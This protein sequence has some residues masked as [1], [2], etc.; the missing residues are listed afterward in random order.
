MTQD[1]NL[2]RNET[3]VGVYLFIGVQ[4]TLDIKLYCISDLFVFTL[5]Q[6]PFFAF[7]GEIFIRIVDVSQ[8]FS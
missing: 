6:T 1:M 7:A 5:T 3:C 4:K 2:I 8:N